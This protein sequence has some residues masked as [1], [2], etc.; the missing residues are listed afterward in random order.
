MKIKRLSTVVVTLA[1]AATMFAGCGAKRANQ[2]L[3]TFN[4][5][6]VIIRSAWWCPD[7]TAEN[8]DTYKECGLNTLLLVN[9]NFRHGD[10]GTS[11]NQVQLT[12]EGGYYIGT[13]QGF[14]GE[15]MTDKALALAK[16]K[17]FTVAN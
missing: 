1:I 10:F 12:K 2:T 8:Y 5:E 16:E 3:P 11:D 4:D 6:D 7:P 15:T 9:H 13:P 17:G 14:E